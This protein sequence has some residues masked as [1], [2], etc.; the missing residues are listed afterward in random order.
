[1]KPIL[2]PT[3]IDTILGT[4][5]RVVP[6]EQNVRSTAA[7]QPRELVEITA[8]G[9]GGT[10]NTSSM[11][12][13][14]W[15]P[16][17]TTVIRELWVILG[18]PTDSP[19]EVTV[20]IDD[21]PWQIVTVE[22]GTTE[23]RLFLESKPIEPTSRIQIVSDQIDEAD[24]EWIH[25]KL[26]GVSPVPH[27]GSMILG[28][29]DIQQ[30]EDVDP[31]ALRIGEVLD[32]AV[33]ANGKYVVGGYFTYACQVAAKNIARINTDG[34]L[35]TTFDVGV[36]PN[37]PVTKIRIQPDG[38]ILCAMSTS[39]SQRTTTW[40]NVAF[41]ML[42]RINAN[43][44]LDTGFM[45]SGF[46][47]GVT[48]VRDFTLLTDGKILV[49]RQ[50]TS[51]PRFALLN[52]NGTLNRLVEVNEFTGDPQN[53]TGDLSRMDWLQTV[54]ATNVI[55]WGTDNFVGRI[56]K[57]NID[58]GVADRLPLNGNTDAIGPISGESRVL[59]SGHRVFPTVYSTTDVIGGVVKVAS[60]WASWTQFTPYELSDTRSLDVD[61][62]NKIVLGGWSIVVDGTFEGSVVRMNSS[63]TLDTTFDASEAIS[64]DADPGFQAQKNRRVNKVV[65]LSSGKYLVGGNFRT[66]TVAGRVARQNF[67]R[68]NSNGTLD[69]TFPAI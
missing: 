33:D 48:E 12:S 11:R 42:C 69:T 51:G 67:V 38:K 63:G 65:A 1:M 30:A 31:G 15:R 66:A 59:A 50:L 20:L 60:D 46:P 26:V 68:L 44:S 53:Q 22:A 45:A 55:V 43:G 56:W 28:F 13:N 32:V 17:D 21:E 3:V 57:F 24:A 14:I 5:S 16:H 62:N 37:R 41:P 49:R 2:P 35:D 61:G 7:N 34:T 64:Q 19:T 9:V 10:K 36:G 47:E 8:A 39:I 40:N 58:T 29:E 52:S 27:T 23:V 6:V 54:D 18:Q 4:Q 25:V